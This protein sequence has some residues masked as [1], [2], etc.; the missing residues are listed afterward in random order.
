MKYR[1][2]L[3]LVLIA[4]ISSPAI[5]KHDATNDSHSIFTITYE[6]DV[7]FNVD[8]R[9]TNGER[10]SWI[11]K[12]QDIPKFMVPVIDNVLK[13][14]TTV[15]P[16][17]PTGGKIRVGY[18]FGQSMFSPDDIRVRTLIKDD[19]PYAG[20]LYG[21][22]GVTYET[23]NELN[24][25]ELTAGMLGPASL[26]EETQKFIHKNIT[27]SPEPKGWDNQLKNEP[28]LMLTYERKWKSLLEFSPF[29]VGVDF[30]PHAGVTLGNIITQG[31]LGGTFR[32]GY[33]LPADYGPPRVRPSISGSD[34]FEPNNKFSWY[35]FAGAEGRGV[36]RNIFLDGNTFTESHHVERIPF[37]ADAQIGVAMI[38]S[39]ARIAYTHVFRSQEYKG[40]DSADQFG[41]IT[42]SFRF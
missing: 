40:Q 5:A 41:A 19:R 37:V 32:I 22:V 17:F 36:A 21:S 18:S 3:P 16:Q 35:F 11:G 33:D 14:I 24:F 20:W 9:Y 38:Y 8:R 4:L 39:K 29:G 30:T 7:F 34:F 10:F 42:V 23:D 2:I 25:V 28:G 15:I 1:F 12:E 26:A 6:N 27:N 13:P 31:T